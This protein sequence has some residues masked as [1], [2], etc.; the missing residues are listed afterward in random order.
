MTTQRILNG[1]KIAPPALAIALL[2]GCATGPDQQMYVDWIAVAN[3]ATVCGGQQDCVQQSMYRGRKM[4][5]IVTANKS[6]SYE[7]LGEHV[8][9]CIRAPAPSASAAQ[10]RR[11]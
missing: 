1:Q 9:A 3:P 11:D 6:V 5:T 7:R 4:C 2:A 10:L 8:R